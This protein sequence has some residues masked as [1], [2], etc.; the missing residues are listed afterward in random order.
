MSTQKWEVGGVWVSP[1]NFLKNY[2][3]C[4][5]GGSL[6]TS[7]QQTAQN[8]EFSDRLP[9]PPEPC[10]CQPCSPQGHPLEGIVLSWL[11]SK[12]P[13]TLLPLPRAVLT[14]NGGLRLR[15]GSGG[16]LVSV[17]VG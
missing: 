11:L 12:G 8:E 6:R 15:L 9:S 17:C 16:E 2:A 14:C 7:P 10:N 1:W 5:G 4:P 3:W 13:G